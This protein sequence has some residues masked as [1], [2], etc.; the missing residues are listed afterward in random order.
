MKFFNR[1]FAVVLAVGLTVTS[2]EFTELDLQENPNAPGPESAELEFLY[3]NIQL[4]FNGFQR[5]TVGFSGYYRGGN[6]MGNFTY[7]NSAPA[8]RGNGLWS[9]FY[10]GL[11]PDIDALIPIA[12]AA[13]A[14]IEL[15]SA[16]IM[17]AYAMFTL[18]DLFGNVPLS[19]AGQGT[20]IISPK[21]DNA[22]EVYQA[23]IALLDEGIANLEGTNAGAPA[24]DIYYDG[25][26]TKWITLANTLKLRAY[27]NIRMVDAN[28]G[29]MIAS[30]VSGGDI[31][32]AASEDFTFKY[33]NQRVNPNSRHPWYNNAYEQ[34]D[35][36]Y[37]PN[38]FL[39]LLAEEKGIR[40]PRTRF[41]FYR[42]RSNSLTADPNAYS[43]IYNEGAPD[44]AFYPAHYA[45]VDPN[46][47]YCVATDDGY[48][49]RD[50]G[51]GSGIPPDGPVRTVYGIYPAGGN[52]DDSQF[53]FTQ[54]NGEDGLLGQGINPIW[55]SSWTHFVLAEAA[56]MAG[57]GGDARALLEEGIRQSIAKVRS[58]ESL[59]D[60]N[61]VIGTLP[62]GEDILLGEALLDP[63]D[64][65]TEDYV[66]LVLLNYDTAPD[67]DARLDIIVKEY[68]IALWGNGMEGYNLYRR[69]AKPD[70]IQPTIDPS[71]G[72]FIQTLLYPSDHVNR[73][74]NVTQK[75]TDELPFWS[76]QDPSKF[77]R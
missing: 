33:G 30:I 73:N 67:D 75:T 20:D 22:A 8:T 50:H 12:E 14:D 58:Y 76:T 5:G 66:D 44:P 55:L 43:C 15:G 17:K 21:A 49:G 37:I 27:S 62:T 23:A 40:D 35:A 54:N 47:P 11:L 32:D 42:Q 1:I 29:S 60:R 2:C 70:N 45:A 24:T 68:M 64:Q 9:S 59:I 65:A 41:Y 3:N 39:W 25:D 52:F 13:G 28:A 53:E 71:S 61:K 4:S 63:L 57:T 34:S 18:V 74:A 38:Y 51:N 7:N 10:A 46:L 31:I 6:N 69:T 26:P 77:N 48:Y 19:E 56:L 16:K 36:S 72:N